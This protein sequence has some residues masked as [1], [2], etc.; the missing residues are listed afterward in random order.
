MQLPSERM[1]LT[2]CTQVRGSQV[3]SKSALCRKTPSTLSALRNLLKTVLFCRDALP[4][5]EGCDLDPSWEYFSCT[6]KLAHR[7][8]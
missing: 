8:P 1:R 3:Q 5:Y 6:L 4:S 2:G 7:A